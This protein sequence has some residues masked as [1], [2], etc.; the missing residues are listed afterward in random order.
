MIQSSKELFCKVKSISY[1]VTHWIKTHGWFFSIVFLA[2]IFV[3]IFDLVY[4]S[5]HFIEVYESLSDQH[6]CYSSSDRNTLIE[7]ASF[8]DVR[9][10]HVVPNPVVRNSASLNNQK[11]YAYMVE[12]SFNENGEIPIGSEMT[13]IYPDGT[14]VISQ[15]LSLPP[16][17]IWDSKSDKTMNYN[18]VLIGEGTIFNATYIFVVDDQNQLWLEQY[19]KFSSNSPKILLK[20]QNHLSNIFLYS[21]K[22]NENEKSKITDFYVNLQQDRE[23]STFLFFEPI[24]S[25]QVVLYQ[26]EK[27]QVRSIRLQLIQIRNHSYPVILWDEVEKVRKPLHV[28]SYLYNK[29]KEIVS[30]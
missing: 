25:H 18:P 16:N 23:D 12:F 20:T 21:D 19:S 15:V 3:L 10:V 30:K 29:F 27:D 9:F 28:T 7:M 11:T 26:K 14:K 17:N 5:T 24:D 22:L 4:S 6:Y 8:N 1:K 2:I 13:F